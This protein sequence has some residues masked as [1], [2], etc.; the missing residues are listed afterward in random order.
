MH[1]KNKRRWWTRGVVFAS[2]DFGFGVQ[3]TTFWRRGDDGEDHLNRMTDIPDIYVPEDCATVYY[4]L[5]RVWNHR[6]DGTRWP[7]LEVSSG[8][9]TLCFFWKAHESWNSQRV[10]EQLGGVSLLVDSCS[11]QGCWCSLCCGFLSWMD[12]WLALVWCCRRSAV[13]GILSS[14]IE[15]CVRY[16]VL[17]KSS[18]A[19]SL[20]RTCLNARKLGG[21]FKVRCPPSHGLGR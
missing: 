5:L 21:K 4:G 10:A 15:R 17:N 12:F 8:F 3:C 14:F 19:G 9:F 6:V 20:R 1:C 7:L 18:A 2:F 16:V 13:V 11:F